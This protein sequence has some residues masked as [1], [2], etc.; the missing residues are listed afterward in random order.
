MRIVYELR[1]RLRAL[2]SRDADE[3][4]MEE[5]LRHHVELETAAGVRR[6]MTPEA[7]R[8]QALIVFGSMD[9]YKDEVRDA[10]GWG[11][12]GEL[13]RDARLA[14]RQFRRSPGF[15]VAAVLT[16][17]VGIG[18]NAAMFGI[19]DGILLRPL[20]Y[21]EPDELVRIYSASEE[22]GLPRA[23]FSG[24]DF[25][26]WRARSRAFSHMAAYF[27]STFIIGE[28]GAAREIDGALVGDGFFDLF[29][30]PI[31]R[32]RPL[33]DEDTRLARRS[34]VISDALWRGEFGADPTIVGR[35]M[36][37]GFDTDEPF[38]IVGV[39][40]PGFRF[41]RPTTEV[42]IPETLFTEDMIGPRM[43][44]N[45]YLEGIA[46]LAPGVEPGRAHAELN[47]LAAQIAADHPDTNSE[48]RAATV[49]PLREVVVG[50]VDRALVIVLGVVGFILLIA[51]ANLANLLL[52][53][54]AG[55]EREM[56]IR[57]ALGAR[58]GRLVR[59]LMTESIMLALI[60]GAAGLVISVWVTRAII[61]L[62][63]ETLPRV[64]A[65]TF[66]A[67]VV[68]FGIVLALITGVLFGLVP[69]AR[70][71]GTG[72]ADRL[73]GGRGSLGAVG[74]RLRSA[75]VIAETALAVILVIG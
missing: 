20:P 39:A 65:V 33:D 61:G 25:E 64:E 71:A 15:T 2:F 52:A 1:E 10:R 21:H 14:L 43:R 46:R 26:D 11:L 53:R 42:W 49:V 12:L 67:R 59:Q 8:R 47:A 16:V 75:L 70:V 37:L 62:S 56:A 55:R 57:S 51:C 38:T 5:E 60:G 3:R 63:A 23:R 54:G 45:R 44:A 31:A 9:R 13:V 29:G 34:V 18:A 22:H 48:W 40:A 50:D 66:D 7:A 41:P 17:A 24:E 32:G 72:A 28:S 4:G 27:A 36:R 73:R 69:A 19:V 6:G 58:R 74:G 30:V 35:S 68:A